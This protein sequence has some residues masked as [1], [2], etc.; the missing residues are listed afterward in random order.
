M[1]PLLETA[2]VG[3]AVAKLERIN[4]QDLAVATTA[5][6]ARYIASLEPGARL[7]TER[8][9][10]ER[11]GVGRSTLREAMGSLSFIG[12]VQTRQ[13][14]GTYV[15][16]QEDAPVEKLIGLALMLQRSS[17]HEIIDVR[18]ILEV[19]AARLAAER[20]DQA[21]RQALLAVMDAMSK[22]VDDPRQAS[23]HDIKFHI[24]LTRASHN[25]ALAHLLNGMRALLQEWIRRAVT[26]TPVVQDIVR[27]HNDILQAVFKRA[28]DQAAAYTLIHLTNA[29]D[30][31]FAA[32]GKNQAAATYIS[33]LLESDSS[34][35]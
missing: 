10:C 26:T 31:L 21:D 23:H 27:E 13:G 34:D 2:G 32:V 33:L 35:V 4:R 1:N 19:E 16:A 17:V 22:S 20:H 28:P 30:R 25:S 7:P 29:A 6:L 5:R 14:S 8:E 18:R 15:T 11:L 12:A 24:L 9:L 3:G